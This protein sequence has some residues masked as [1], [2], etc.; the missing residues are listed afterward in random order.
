MLVSYWAQ[1]IRS[2]SLPATS[3]VRRTCLARAGELSSRR[4]FSE[5]GAQKTKEIL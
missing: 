1:K 2:S 4:F 5:N 3:T